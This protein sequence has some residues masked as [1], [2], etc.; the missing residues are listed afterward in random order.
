MSY[1]TQ[2]TMILDA[3]AHELGSG[4][5][6][7]AITQV[8]GGM[9]GDWFEWKAGG[10]TYWCGNNGDTWAT[11]AYE[12]DPY[13]DFAGPVAVFGTDVP[14]EIMDPETVAVAV[15]ASLR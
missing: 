1:A 11:A 3:L 6:Q 14:S 10:R 9:G 7:L 2:M 12:G 8:D 15:A 13:A 5:R 4:G